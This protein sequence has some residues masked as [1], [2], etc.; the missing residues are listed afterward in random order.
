M[1]C[2]T[3]STAQ[4]SS[5][6]QVADERGEL[7]D[8]VGGE[9]A[10]GSSSSSSRGSAIRARA[11]A[12][13]LPA[14]TRRQ[15]RAARS[16]RPLVEHGQSAAVGPSAGLVA[17]GAGQAE[18]PRDEAGPGVAVGAGQHVLEHGQSAEQADALQG[19]GDAAAGELVR[20]GMQ[21]GA[22]QERVCR[23]AAATNPQTTLNRVVLPAP[24]GPMTPTTWPAVRRPRPRPAR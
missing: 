8:L 1:W 12:D 15:R 14:W 18:Q 16:A 9:P 21:R 7:V 2:S 20:R 22:V 10:A 17:V 24:F 19:A 23:C 4:P 6:R 13:A 5:R 3:S 11:S